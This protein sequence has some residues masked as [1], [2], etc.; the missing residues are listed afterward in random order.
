M[1][2][3]H[4]VTRTFTLNDIDV[5]SRLYEALVVHAKA[6]K[7]E[8][9]VYK[10]LLALARSL[11]PDDEILKRARPIGIGP[12]LLFVEAFCRSSGYPNLACLAVNGVTRRPGAG[13]PGDWDEDRRAVA[14]FDW[15]Q[16]DAGMGAFAGATRQALPPKRTR[17]RE[18]EARALNFEYFRANRSAYAKVTQDGK[19]EIIN[20]LMDGLDPAAALAQALI[21]QARYGDGGLSD[22][23][24]A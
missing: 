22:E 16:V 9:I 12:K 7:G 24:H 14:A 2:D 19:E 1:T 10:D 3:W 15:S 21:A 17:L 11:H 5:G 20:L 23:S 18:D 4:D 13:Y 8:P 6:Q